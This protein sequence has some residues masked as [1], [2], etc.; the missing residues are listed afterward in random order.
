MVGE[1]IDVY[2]SSLEKFPIGYRDF[3]KGDFCEV[4][5]VVPNDTK[6]NEITNKYPYIAKFKILME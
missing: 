4:I 6:I 1:I 2:T 5:D 3:V